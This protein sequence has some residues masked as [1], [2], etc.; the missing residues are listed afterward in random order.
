MGTIRRASLVQMGRILHA[1]CMYSSHRISR[2]PGK[3][4]SFGTRP[5]LSSSKTTRNK[6][7]DC[8]WQIHHAEVP[9]GGRGGAGAAG[10]FL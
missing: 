3:R 4:S 5:R 10:G 8:L 6:K 2:D 7:F 9:E 1:S